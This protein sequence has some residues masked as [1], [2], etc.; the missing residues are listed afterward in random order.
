MSDPFDQ[1]DRLTVLQNKIAELHEELAATL[2]PR[3][4]TLLETQLAEY[5]AELATLSAAQRQNE[6]PN[7]LAIEQANAQRDVFIASEQ[8]IHVHANETPSV[9]PLLR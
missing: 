7:D 8:T 6:P 9:E 2:R 3:T 4:R 1:T 5:Q